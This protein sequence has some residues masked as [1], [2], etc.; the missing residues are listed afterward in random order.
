MKAKNA[1]IMLLM[2]LVTGPL[3]AQDH[4]SSTFS[5][6][7]DRKD[8]TAVLKAVADWQISQPLVHEPADWTN[9]ALYAGMAEWASI[10]G[11]DRYYEWLKTL[12]DKCSWNYFR[13]DDPLRRYHADDYCVGQVYIELYRKYGKVY[14]LKPIKTYLNSIL[15]DPPKGD[16]EFVNTDKHWSTERWSWCD[17]LFMGPTVWA[18]MAAVTGKQK[19][20]DFMYTEYKAT[21]D[22]LYDK[23]EHLYYRDSNYFNKKEANGEKVF[24]GRGNGWVF[25]GLPIIIREL[26]EGYIHK[27]YFVKIFR[28]MAV[29]LKSLQV[30][31]GSWHASLLDPATY[32]NPEMSATAFIVFGMAWGVANGYLDRDD[33][34]PVI[35]RG[36]KSMVASVW[37]NGKVGYIQPIGADPKS[38]TRDMTEVYGVGGF[39]MAGTEIMRLINK[40]IL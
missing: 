29:R 2:L 16:L 19:Y 33:Y 36:W 1:L 10:A 37:P 40:G 4:P 3:F 20:L 34:L 38:V 25:A 8:V 14:M 17:A 21:T 39:L 7:I 11:T 31:D 35:T 18:K 15:R 30:R 26:P 22:Y 23:E 28:E 6:N 12:A 5:N 24:W 27:D 13:H 32:P 9:A